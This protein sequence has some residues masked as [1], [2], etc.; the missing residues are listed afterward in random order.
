MADLPS[1]LRRRQLDDAAKR[2]PQVAGR[3]RVGWIRVTREALGMSQAQLAER[4]G[5]SRATVQKLELAETRRRIT[6]ASL[7]RMAA[8]LGCEVAMTLV[9]VGGSHEV[10]RVQ[11]AHAKAEATLEPVMHSMMLEG[12]AMSPEN[13]ALIKEELVETL[14]RGNP[15]KLWR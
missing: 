8:A 6:L 13:R 14:L 11:Q 4:A 9:P 7:D 15:R 5:V 1:R 3:P 10:V 12:Q 2:F